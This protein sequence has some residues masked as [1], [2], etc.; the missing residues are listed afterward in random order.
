MPRHGQWFENS[1][2]G[3]AFEYFE[4]IMTAQSRNILNVNANSELASMFIPSFSWL[5]RGNIRIDLCSFCRWDQDD[6]IFGSLLIK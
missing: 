3:R 6:R 4:N 2:G 5:D 1:L